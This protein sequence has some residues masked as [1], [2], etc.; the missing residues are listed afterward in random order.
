VIDWSAPAP[1]PFPKSRRDSARENEVAARIPDVPTAPAQESPSQDQEIVPQYMMES[2]LPALRRDPT[3]EN[4]ER[5]VKLP[6]LPE[7]RRNSSVQDYINKKK[8][9]AMNL[10]WVS[11]FRLPPSPEP[12]ATLEGRGT[13]KEELEPKPKQEETARPTPFEKSGLPSR[14][15]E[16]ATPA[17]QEQPEEE[18]PEE[19]QPNEEQFE[20]KVQPEEEIQPKKLEG[21]TQPKEEAQLEEETQ[22]G[23]TQPEKAANVGDRKGSCY[24]KS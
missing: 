15:D 1:T 20:D 21:E 7:P 10:R 14:E 12:P 8:N 6:P 19:K 4:F 24:R 23:E 2:Q 3:L 13:N 5:A 9:E 22:P 17:E 16:G 11:R 18:E